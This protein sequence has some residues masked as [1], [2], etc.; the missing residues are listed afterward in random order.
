[1]V[2]LHAHPGAGKTMLMDMFYESALVEKKQRVH[3]NSFMLNVH[4]S[5]STVGIGRAAIGCY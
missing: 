2:D 3:F 4:D 1:M 5:K